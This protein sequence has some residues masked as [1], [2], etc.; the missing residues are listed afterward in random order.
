VLRIDTDPA[1]RFDADPY[2]D[3]ACHC[4]KDPEPDPTFHSQHPDRVQTPVGGIPMDDPDPGLGEPNRWL[5]ECMYLV[6]KVGVG[7]EVTDRAPHP[8]SRVHQQ[9]IPFLPTKGC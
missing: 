6:A 5:Y 3:P 1:C 2:P 9:S 4:D 7:D 8:P